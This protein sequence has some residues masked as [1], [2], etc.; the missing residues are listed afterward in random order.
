MIHVIKKRDGKLVSYDISKIIIAISKAIEAVENKFDNIAQKLDEHNSLKLANE[1]EKTLE[2]Q[3]H[4]PSVE[5]IQDAVEKIL[6]KNNFPEAA[7]AFILYRD[8]HNKIRDS[9]KLVV[10]IINTMDGYLNQSDWRVKENSNVNFSLGGLI[11]HNSGTMTANYWLNSIYS[12]DVADAHKSGDMHI[13][14]LSMFSGYCFTGDTKV[15]LLDGTNRTFK[16]LVENYSDKTFW[17]YSI[18]EHNHIVPG[19]ARNP[20]LTRQNAEIICIR[21]DNNEMIK[22]TKDHPFLMRNGQYKQASELQPGDSLMPMYD[23]FC[24]GKSGRRYK[25]FRN[26]GGKRKYVHRQVAEYFYN[27]DIKNKHIHHING[28]RLDNRPENLLV[29]ISKDHRGMEFKRTMNEETW[30]TSNNNRLQIYNRSVEKRQQISNIACNRERNDNGTFKEYEKELEYN[31]KVRS[32]TPLQNEDVYDITVDKFHNFALSAG[33]FVHNCAGWSLRDLLLEGLGGIP[34]KITSKP[35]KHLS[36]VI[37]QMVNFLGILQNE[38]AGAMAFSSFDTYLAPFVRV[39]NLTYDEVK[40][41]VQ[42]FIF[43]VNTPSRWGSQSPFT[44]VTF[45]WTVPNDLK[46]H[47]AIVGGKTLDFTYGDCQKEMDVIN[48]AFLEVFFEGDGEGRGFSYPIPT[49]NITK[50][51]DWESDNAKLL[52]KMTGKYGTPYF[53]NFINSDLNPSDVRSMCVT[54]DTLV[55]VKLVK[56][57]EKYQKETGNKGSK[58][59]KK[60]IRINELFEKYNVN[61]FQIMTSQGYRF[62]ERKIITE[63]DKLIEIVTDS[64]KTLRMTPNHPSLVYGK[65][66]EGLKVILAENLKPGMEVSIKQDLNGR[67]G[68]QWTELEK[69]HMSKVKKE[70]RSKEE[71][72]LKFVGKRNGMFNKIHT[73]ETKAKISMNCQNHYVSENCKKKSSDRWSGLNNPVCKQSYWDRKNFENNNMQISDLE[74]IIVNFLEIQGHKYIFQKVFTCNEKDKA[75]V[76]DF[77]IPEKNLVVESVLDCD[78]LYFNDNSTKIIPN[79]KYEF[80]KQ[81]GFDVVTVNPSKTDEWIKYLNKSEQIIAVNQIKLDKPCKVYDV[82]IKQV[83]GSYEVFD[84]YANN[85]LTHNCC[86]LRLDKR[87]INARCEKLENKGGGLFGAAELTGSVGVVTINMPRIGF[88]SATKEEYFNRLARVMDTAR[89]SLEVKRKIV[90]AMLDVGLFPYSKRYLKHGFKNHF[91]TIGLI[92]M[93]ESTLNFMGLDL[94]NEQARLFAKEVLDF[95]R[96]K[97]VAYQKETGYLYNLEATPGEGT[98]YRLAKIDKEQYSDIIVSGEKEPYYTNSTQLPV[99]SSDDIF[100]SLDMQ[101]SLQVKYTGGTVFHG[102]L[103]ESIDD[104]SIVK[105]LIKKIASNY[106]LPYFTLTPTFSI[107]RNH[108]YL[109]GEQFRCPKC[110]LET[111]VYSRIVGYYRP[112]QHWNVGKKSEYH[113]RLEYT[114]NQTAKDSFITANANAN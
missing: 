4:I 101:D 50:D 1:V 57:I 55:H 89:N 5:D 49:Y 105:D 20:K 42:S 63:T 34:G 12:K 100:E 17:V 37:N 94:T 65:E 75:F 86:R 14:D 26:P 60:Q 102:F 10:D 77:F 92:G 90:T 9:K 38:W 8:Q 31:H 84:F 33:V 107:C 82:E 76:A 79:R 62:C 104:I 45:D 74:K 44:N 72:R 95:M 13:H 15:K 99:N 28:N 30:Q 71:N 53:Q 80:Y 83:E 21:L 58:K 88:L 2:Q 40:Q 68:H 67:S 66:K 91:S 23:S 27:C 18:D 46:D 22:C 48:K 96:N 93:N 61:E 43:G 35:A 85:I 69:E 98:S 32:I 11:L 41:H 51:F 6:I 52:Y 64:G 78:D 24:A 47:P 108:G 70:F 19:L 97:L 29:M 59:F 111:E 106:H 109:K 7:K 56:E 54:G 16:E 112:V 25:R 110:E 81:Q 36:T 39:D 3:N 87:E 114:V 103:N 73:D 113:D